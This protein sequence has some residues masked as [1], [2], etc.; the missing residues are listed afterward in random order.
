[1]RTREKHRI[2]LTVR[3]R[4]AYLT[5]A[6]ATAVQAACDQSGTG[7]RSGIVALGP[8]RAI[9]APAGFGTAPMFAVGAAGTE[10]I[11]WVSAP[12][13][14]TDG[15][16]MVSVA[17]RAPVRLRDPLGPIE[18][19]GE[20]PPKIAFGAGDTLDV[21]YSVVREDSAARFPLS[22]LRFARSPDGGRSWSA[23]VTVTG[24]TT[25][26]GRPGAAFGS[27]GFHALHVSADGTIYVA[28]LGRESDDSGGVSG[29]D[30]GSAAW[31][32]RS[33]DGGSTWAPSVR[34]DR[35]E[36][37]PCCR[38]A[39]ATAPDGTVY[40]A[41]RH[42][43]PGSVRDIV[44]ARSV[45]RGATW[46][47]PRRVHADNW[48]YDGC[49][50]AGPSLEVDSA[51]VVHVAWWTGK[52]GRPGVYYA[53]STDGG[54]TYSPPIALGVARYS[55]PAHVQLA[56]AGGGRLVTVWDDGT[57]PLP[58]V[59]LRVSDDGGE[60]FGP[61]VV[62]SE[63]GA[64]SAFPVLGVSGMSVAVAWSE[65]SPA[66]A[67]AEAR[68]MPDMRRPGTRMGIR[69]VGDRHVLVWRGMLR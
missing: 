58:R 33:T 17:G 28:W 53:R 38:T 44:V 13:G 57:T 16:V 7:S 50:H 24:E 22:A 27:H 12:G 2:A 42:V 21:V 48:R 62:L 55:S 40:L 31:I 66:A 32:T 23:P 52:P 34:V 39:L 69:A 60:R 6:V 68:T 61:A 43:F 4:V 47:A 29:S 9:A 64:A 49:P 65:Q 8:V 1:M 36:A 45:D 67:A 20:S 56:L 10:A 3:R 63:P 19:H 18:A 51:G 14:G 46:S 15:R 37:C 54:T 30:G 5:A 35:G 41:W 26:S 25:R 11:A 59:L